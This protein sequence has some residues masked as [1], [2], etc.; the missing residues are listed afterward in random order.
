M[1]KVVLEVL[2]LMNVI[3][4]STFTVMFMQF[5]AKLSEMTSHSNF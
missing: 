2:F 4:H 3:S 1:R 5:S